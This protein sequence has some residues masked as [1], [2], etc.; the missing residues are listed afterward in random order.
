[1]L[2]KKKRLNILKRDNY[3]CKLC[4]KK[5]GKDYIQIVDDLFDEGFFRQPVSNAEVCERVSKRGIV[6]SSRIKGCINGKI[7]GMAK[8]KKLA[9]FKQGNKF[10]YQER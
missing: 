5:C 6:L 1:M 8:A 2:S 4:K 3:T 7:Q 9:K 10:V